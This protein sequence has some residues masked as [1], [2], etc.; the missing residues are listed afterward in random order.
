MFKFIVGLP[1]EALA[2]EASRAP[3]SPVAPRI[4]ASAP[5]FKSPAARFRKSRRRY[6][7]RHQPKP[8]AVSVSSFRPSRRGEAVS[9]VD[10]SEARLGG[11]LQVRT[12]IMS[13]VIARLGFRVE[14]ER[15][16]MLKMKSRPN[17]SVPFAF[18]ALVASLS[19]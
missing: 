4:S 16:V 11:L 9:T 13:G 18:A 1:P 2:I 12:T 19:R 3:K 15:R 6:G 7:L 10:G 17:G 14:L 5:P 8:S